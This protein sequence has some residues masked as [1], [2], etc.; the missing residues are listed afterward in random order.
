[1]LICMGTPTATR[2]PYSLSLSLHG[3]EGDLYLDGVPELVPVLLAALARD[4]ADDPA[5]LS[6]ETRADATAE[7]ELTP[8]E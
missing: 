7:P 1:M 4:A 6:R 2:S 3:P 8:L 5:S